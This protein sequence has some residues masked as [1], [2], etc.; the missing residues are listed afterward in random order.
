MAGDADGARDALLR[1][2]REAPSDARPLFALAA[3]YLDTRQFGLAE[4]AYTSAA[5]RGLDA[6]AALPGQARALA[7][8]MKT[9]EALRVVAT[10]LKERPTDADLLGLQ[11]DVLLQAGKPK[12][13]LAS[14][15]AGVK[16]APRSLGPLLRLVDALIA[17]GQAIEASPHLLE[18][19][20]L[21]PT[22]PLP[23]H[24]FGL[25][26]MSARN[27]A[28]AAGH[29]EKAAKRAPQE[30]RYRL[31]WADAIVQQ[32]NAQGAQGHFTEAAGLYEQ[33]LSRVPR[34]HPRWVDM[35]GQRDV[36]R[37]LESFKPMWGKALDWMS[38]TGRDMASRPALR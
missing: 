24:R 26:C 3:L 33:A 28:E 18:A 37:V 27:Y 31:A 21:A 1:A 10:A 17:M 5:R 19:E 16:A 8:Q 13:A 23:P 34:S 15:E 2:R 35:E 12:E 32:G 38:K 7:K 25:L 30:L 6:P 9:T 20:K 29:F 14:L 36:A 11:A 22:S 4:E